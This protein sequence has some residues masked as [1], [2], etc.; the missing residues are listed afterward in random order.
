M[1]VPC[2]ALAL[3]ALA[4]VACGDGGG[5]PDAPLPDSP[6]PGGTLSLQWSLT[7]ANGAAIT[8]E[9]VGAQV[10]TLVLRNRDVSGASTEVFVCNSMA[11]TTPKVPPGTY[12]VAFQLQHGTYGLIGQATTQLGV[13]VESNQNTP[14]EPVVFAVDATGGLDLKLTANKPGGNCGPAP[15]GAGITGTSITLTRGPNDTCE[16]VT[17]T[18]SGNPATMYTVNCAN[19]TVVGCIESN[20]SITVMGVPTNTYRIHVRGK[21][22][23][24]D[25]YTNDDPLMVPPAGNTLTRTLNLAPGC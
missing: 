24:V 8:C 3:G 13:V 2:R 22:N 23:G 15:N 9:R 16:P 6:L 4:L 11:G 12:D 20:Q 18:I 7:D 25:C 19:P 10:V 17:F 1:T 21:V 5:F 14:L